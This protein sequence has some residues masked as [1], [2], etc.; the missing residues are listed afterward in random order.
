MRNLSISFCFVPKSLLSLSFVGMLLSICCLLPV[1]LIGQDLPDIPPGVVAWTEPAFPTPNDDVT[2]YFNAKE[3]NGGL[4]GFTGNVYAHTGVLTNLSFNDSDWKHVKT[5]WP[6][7]DPEILM[8]RLAE[9]LYSISYNIVEFYGPDPGE[10]IQKLAFVFRSIDGEPSGRATDGGDIFLDVFPAN[11]G[12]ILDILSPQ[13]DEIISSGEDMNLQ[14]Q[15]N[16]EATLEITDN[17]ST[18]FSGIAQ[19]VDLVIPNP[20]PGIHLVVITASVEEESIKDSVS[21]LV[22]RER[23]RENPPPGTQLGLTYTDSS[24][25]FAL[26]A[27]EKTSVS[28]LCPANNFSFVNGFQMTRSTVGDTFWVELS[29]DL[30]DVRTNTYQF[31]VD[32]QIAI[33]DPY[34]Q[35]VLDQGQDAFIPSRNLEGLPPFP[36]GATGIVTVFDLN[37]STF[38]WQVDTFQAPAKENLVIYELLLR[39]FL[40]D[41]SYRSLIDTLD[42]LADL[43]VNAIELMPVQEFE[44]NLSWG[45]NPSFHFAVDKYYGSRAELK[46]FIDA[47]HTKG[48]AVI[49]DVVYNHV[50]GQAPFARMY[51]DNAN[52]RP[53]ANNPW[54]NPIPRHPFN[55]GFDVDHESPATRSWVKRNLS[56][57]VEEY[58]IDGFRFDLS[59]GLTQTNSGS[60]PGL[61]SQY[62]ASRIAILKDYADHVWR[63]N[64][65]TYVI[66]EHFADN[67]EEVEL[68]N[69]GM[70]LWGNMNFQFAEAA[71]GYVS[72][73]DGANYQARGW[74]NPHLISYMESHDE[75]RVMYKV[76]QFGN[77]NGSYNTKNIG[78]ALDRIE[79]ISALYYT[80]PG[81]KMLWQFGELGYDFS[82]NQCQNG[83]VS[84]GCRLDVKPIRWDYLQVPDRKAL[85]DRV[86]RIVQLKT[87][88]STFSTRDFQLDDTDS[89]VKQLRLNHPD[90]DAFVITNFDVIERSVTALFPDS[91]TWHEFFS[92]DSLELNAN[93][94][95]MTLAPGAY[96]IYTSRRIAEEGGI[97]TNNLEEASN[98]PMRVYPNPLKEGQTLQLSLPSTPQVENIKLYNL[99]GKSETLRFSLQGAS[100]N[101]TIP[102]NFPAGMYILQISFNKGTTYQKIMIGG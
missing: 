48:I 39:D 44:A 16:V 10:E 54:L 97:I 8:T 18:L 12:L 28:F 102:Q 21:Y 53:A 9:D 58:R 87:Q 90:M 31:L 27:P 92:G 67:R 55:V 80:I 20:E 79:A 42:Y 98:F 4:E 30:F 85:F 2:V 37:P 71:M 1:I 96:R 5:D 38:D 47:A 46:Q 7:D 61:M 69:Y 49:L 76:L 94:Q 68:A 51:W 24:Y 65:E 62:D 32:G 88:F 6:G 45:Y 101:V 99:E 91:G 15:L 81:P 83:P 64:P 17:D 26:H 19:E 72:D 34:A 43:G 60:D 22:L 77:S 14:V 84:E 50:F 56:Q 93:S 78:T 89:Y 41:H 86:S 33:A 82:I 36:G 35:L 75:E 11:S 23:E 63:L 52:N 100:A 13:S 95:S 3:G 25:L 73:L 66:M 59:K 74:S 29:K 70:M 57:W 40:S